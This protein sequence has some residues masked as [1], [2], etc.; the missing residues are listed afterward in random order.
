[1][2]EYFTWDILNN[3]PEYKKVL[4][5]IYIPNGN[6]TNEID[7]ILIN[8][9]GVF[10]IESKGYSGWIFGNETNKTWTQI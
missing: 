2:A 1:M 9:Y 10:V 5:N 4:I 7:S 8:N 3:Q 6:H